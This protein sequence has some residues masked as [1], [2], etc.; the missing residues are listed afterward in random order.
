M[1]LKNVDTEKGKRIKNN[2]ITGLNRGMKNPKTV[3]ENTDKWNAS[4]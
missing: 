4:F 1:D 2:S 3:A